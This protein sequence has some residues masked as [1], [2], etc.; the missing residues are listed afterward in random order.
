VAKKTS[1]D[2]CGLEIPSHRFTVSSFDSKFDKTRSER[3]A[4]SRC[5]M[6]AENALRKVAKSQHAGPRK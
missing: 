2:F 4:C 6:L 5:I 1:C 3:D